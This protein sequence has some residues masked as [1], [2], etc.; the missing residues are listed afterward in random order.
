M[1]P[2]ITFLKKKD[3]YLGIA[4]YILA[5]EMLTYALTKILRTQFVLI[6]FSLW[7]R[8]LESLSGRN[9]AW[10]FLGYSPWFQVLLGFLELIPSVLLLFRRTTFLGAVLMLP[11][12]LSVFLI[13]QALNLWDATKV[14]SLALLALNIVVFLFEWKRIKTLLQIVAGKGVRFRFTGWEIIINVLVAGVVVWFALTDLLDYRNQ[15]NVLTGDWL[16]QHP[17]EWTLKSEKIGDSTL[18]PGL[19]KSYYGAYGEYSEIN[20]TGYVYRNMMSYDFD[21]KKHTL[22]FSNNKTRTYK[23]YSYKLSGDSLLT[24]ISTIDSA[25]NIKLTQQFKKRVINEHAGG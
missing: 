17:V 5:L 24:L 6:P 13:N 3:L 23:K 20:D 7:Q 14:I 4:R 25:K 19:L 22:I 16:N 8:P 2:V 9:L 18:H 15:T 12:T 11:M 1:Q 21:E 10:A